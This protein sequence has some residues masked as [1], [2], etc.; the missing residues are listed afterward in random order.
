MLDQLTSTAWNSNALKKN[1]N[2]GQCSSILTQLT[3]PQAGDVHEAARNEGDAGNVTSSVHMQ[4]RGA[5]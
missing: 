1:L 4:A 3:K 5:A 2:L